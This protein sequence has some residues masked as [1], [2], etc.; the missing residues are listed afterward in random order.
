MESKKNCE[1]QAANLVVL[2]GI[3]ETLERLVP[4]RGAARRASEGWPT[5]SDICMKIGEIH[6]N[7]NRNF[8]TN[9]SP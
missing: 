2:N 6:I 4:T 9:K 3:A 5:E 7:E 8:T 1:G